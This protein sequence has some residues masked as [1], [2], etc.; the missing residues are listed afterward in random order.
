MPRKKTT[1]EFVSDHEETM[2]LADKFTNRANRGAF[3]KGVVAGAGGKSEKDCPYPD[4]RTAYGAPTYS[5]GFRSD[6]LEGLEHGKRTFHGK[7][8]PLGD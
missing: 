8:M 5:R 3:L 2:R 7:L 1:P 4:H 6:W